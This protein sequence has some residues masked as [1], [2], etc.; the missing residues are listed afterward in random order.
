MLGF[1]IIF[2]EKFHTEVGNHGDPE[3]SLFLTRLSPSGLHCLGGNN[4]TDGLLDTMSEIFP[5][6]SGHGEASIA[7]LSTR[8]VLFDSDQPVRP[9]VKVLG[10]KAGL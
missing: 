1:L 4:P 6:G 2:S 10:A 7:A 5:M 3:S 9:F 8:K